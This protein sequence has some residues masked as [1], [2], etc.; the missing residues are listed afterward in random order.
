VRAVALVL[1]VLVL[2]LLAAWFT[3][4]ASLPQLDGEVVAG[5]PP[6]T[7]ERDALGVATVRGATREAVSFGLGFAH[8]QDRFFQMDL[9]RRLAAGEL[10]TLFGEVAA[11]QDA[12][13]GAFGFRA[14][15]REVLRRASSEERANLAAYAQG[16]NAGL[17]SLSSR[18][19]EYWLLRRSPAQWLSEDTILVVYAMWWDLQYEDWRREIVLRTLDERI[20]GPRCASGWKCATQFFYPGGR[21][22]WDAPNGVADL[23]TVALI[24]VP[25]P[26]AID[27]RNSVVPA[28]RLTAP[29]RA[30][31]PG[32]N[33]WVVAG[34]HTA[35]GAALVANDMHLNLRVPN[36]WYRARLIVTGEQPLELNGVT[37]PGAPLLVAGS[38]GYV[39]WG[40]TNSYG[41]WQDV[42]RHACD[43]TGV[44][45]RVAEARDGQC[46]FVRWLA[47]LPEA[48]NVRVLALERA[49][50][51]DEALAL[52]ATIGIP[53]QNFVVGDRDGHIGWTLIGRIPRGT[54]PDRMTGTSGW[55]DPARYPRIVDPEAGRI[56]SA[57]SL[58]TVDPDQQRALADDEAATGSGYDLGA[59]AKQIRLGLFAI[60]GKAAPADMLRVQLDDRA[61]FVEHWRRFLLSLLDTQATADHPQR[62]EFRRLIADWLPRAAPESVGYRLVR[63]AQTRIERAT[64]DMVLAG[65]EIES[66][67]ASVP[68]RFEVPLWK[69]VNEQPAHFLAKPHASW[70]DFLLGEVD[71]TIAELGEQCRTLADCT[72]GKRRPVQIRHP[73]SRAIP[74][75]S[76]FLDMPTLELAG[77]GDMPRVQSGSFG[78]SERFAVSPGHEAQGYLTIAGGQSGHPLSD[79]YRAG[80]EEWAEGKP[81][82]FL[83]GE[84]RHRLTLR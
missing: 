51:V 73:L 26:D 56:W 46:W 30:S 49:R 31:L 80:F 2:A 36:V 18:P 42:S 68:T 74:A 61:E 76:G 54:G 66:E 24:E 5:G 69:L 78:A 11:Q 8:A 72:W 38:N 32:S 6:V 1:V 71:A 55:L 15:A 47:Q 60:E 57:N 34:A 19:W 4:R 40:F 63:G 79:F 50:S 58:T 83:P 64:W 7:I 67:D 16:V 35:T 45:V 52:A 10:V 13:A 33:N 39:A 84:M 59:R 81:L 14:V 70:R 9:S 3:L 20:G 28:A 29:Q 12:R 27:L 37:L 82:P 23:E 43:A 44:G 65:L 48:T 53:H 21:S 41:D 17:A 75:L 62:A 22:E 25:P 77:D